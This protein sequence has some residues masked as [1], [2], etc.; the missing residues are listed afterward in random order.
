MD[1]AADCNSSQQYTQSTGTHVLCVYFDGNSGTVLNLSSVNYPGWPG[2]GSH[3][4]GGGGWI[5]SLWLGNFDFSMCAQYDGTWGCDSWP[6]Q[7][8]QAGSCTSSDECCF[9][10]NDQ[11]LNGTEP[12]NG[13]YTENATILCAADN[14]GCAGY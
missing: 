5:N 13:W 10:P 6:S 11:G 12:Y 14:S 1:S 7:A 8:N 9:Y 2:Y 4:W 3:D